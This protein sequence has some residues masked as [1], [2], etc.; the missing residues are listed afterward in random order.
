MKT[1]EE[2]NYKKK[3]I[4]FVKEA[5]TRQEKTRDGYFLK[6]LGKPLRTLSYL[7][8]TPVSYKVTFLLM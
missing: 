8:I 7:V 2:N 6:V 3:A 4:R 5:L 1:K